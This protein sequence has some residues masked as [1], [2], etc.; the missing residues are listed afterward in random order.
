MSNPD[1]SNTYKEKLRAFGSAMRRKL[2]LLT[3]PELAA[4]LDCSEDTIKMWRRTRTGP[5]P[6]R[7]GRRVFYREAALQKHA[8]EMEGFSPDEEEANGADEA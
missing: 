5:V 8:E 7:F 1:I 6:T 3:S 2:G 4:T